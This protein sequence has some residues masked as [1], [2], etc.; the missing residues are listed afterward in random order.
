MSFMHKITEGPR[1]DG[2]T[3]NVRDLAA[4]LQMSERAAIDAIAELESKG[5]I[6]N[7]TPERK[8]A[9]AVFRLT[10]CPFQG[11]PP[12]EDY[13]NYKLT[14]EEQRRLDQIDRQES[15][16]TALRRRGGSGR[17]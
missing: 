10:T 17:R 5:F 6:V 16:L 4:D 11:N 7:L 2:F 9:N 12:T 14:P 1:R 15:K 3:V 13:L 8:P